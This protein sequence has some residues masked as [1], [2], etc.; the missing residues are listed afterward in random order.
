MPHIEHADNAEPCSRHAFLLFLWIGDLQTA[1]KVSD[2]FTSIARSHSM[3]PHLVVGRGLKAALAIRR[4]DPQTGVESCSTRA[5]LPAAGYG[6]MAAPFDL[7]LAEGFAATGRFAESLSVIDDGIRLVEINGDLIYMPELLRVKGVLLLAMPQPRVEEAEA[8]FV[9]RSNSA[10]NK[11][12]VRASCAPRST[13]Q[14]L[15][16][17]RDDARTPARCSN[18]CSPGSLRARTRTT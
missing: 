9:R 1:E 7:S 6:M 11:A 18:P 4:G 16:P 5:E 12:R 14:G 13:W 17:L 8:I 10:V 3:A 2:W 15:W